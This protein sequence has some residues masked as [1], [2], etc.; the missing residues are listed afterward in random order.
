[1][2]SSI[3][4][5]VSIKRAFWALWIYILT[6]KNGIFPNSIFQLH[7]ILTPLIL[8]QLACSIP[9]TNNTFHQLF[10]YAKKD[11]T[12][13]SIIWENSRNIFGR[14]YLRSTVSKSCQKLQQKII[15][16]ACLICGL[17]TGWPKKL[18]DTFPN[19]L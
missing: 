13:S 4:V 7:P 11:A 15:F 9:K 16:L 12:F 3:F 8:D 10:K 14:I 18:R 6:K 5:F 19:R 2:G 17:T 1:M